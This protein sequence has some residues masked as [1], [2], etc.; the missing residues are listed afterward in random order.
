MRRWLALA[1]LLAPGV[2]LADP[3]TIV[4]TLAPYI[5]GT[6]AAAVA[7]VATFAATYGG[8]IYA[9]YSVY[10]GIQA[11]RD[12]KRAAA[13]A[14]REYNDSLQDRLVTALRADPPWRI[15]YGRAIVGGDIVAVLTSNK[16][17]L[18]NDG[19]TY[20]KPDGLKHLVIVLAAHQVQAIHEVLID[21]IA[22]GTLDGDGWATTG[23]FGGTSRQVYQERVVPAGGS[24]TFPGAPTVLAAG[25]NT[26]GDGGWTDSTYTV[27]GNTV[28]NTA[29]VQAT[30]SVR[31]T[32]QQGTVR[33]EKFLGTADQAASAYLQS[34]CPAEWTANDRLRGLAGVIITLD[35]E[36]PRFQAGPPPLT[37]DVSGRL[38]YDPRT[39]STAY[40]ENPALV[41]RDWLTAPWGFNV[42]PQDIDDAT[43]IAAANA[44]DESISLT[45]GESTTTGARYTCNGATTSDAAPEA[46]L[47]DLARCMAGTATHTGGLWVV[48][49]GVYTPPVLAL[50]EDLKA[51][52]IEVVQAGTGYE[53][54][55]NGVRGSMIERGR[56]VQSDIDPYSNAAYVAADGQELWADRAFRWTDNRARAR[57]LAR[58]WTEQNRESL[59]IQY[60]AKMHAWPLVVG[61]RV[62]VTDAEY[63]WAAKTFR[64][65]DWQWSLESA[66]L[67]TLQEDAASIYDLADAATADSVP[68][69]GL[70]D[71]FATPPA[72]TGLAAASGS[73]HAV[74]Q[75]DGTILDRVRVSWAAIASPY[76]TQ[77]GRVELRWRRLE[78]DTPNAWR[79]LQAPGDATQEYL[80]GARGGDLIVIGATPV[81]SLGARGPEALATHLVVG[82]T[83]PPGNVQNFSVAELPGGLLFDWSRPPDTDYAATVLQ[84]HV[85]GSESTLWDD[86]MP[87]WFEGDATQRLMPWPA[88]GTYAVLARHKDHSGNLSELAALLLVSI[89]DQRLVGITRIWVQTGGEPGQWLASVFDEENG[90]IIGTQPAYW[91][92]TGGNLLIDTPQLEEGAATTVLELEKVYA[93]TVYGYGL[94]VVMGAVVGST[95]ASMVVVTA[96]F[97]ASGVTGFELE[98]WAALFSTPLSAVTFVGTEPDCSD[99]GISAAPPTQWGQA[100]R[101]GAQR[102]KTSITW[103]FDLPAG[104]SWLVGLA[105]QNALFATAGLTFY[106]KPLLQLQ[107]IKA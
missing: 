103:T 71:P 44:C 61:D 53:D 37:F 56:G 25:Y 92:G 30:I 20:T 84:L 91:V 10:G 104:E 89:E 58:I 59:V 80:I 9:A 12:A 98:R 70:P 45:V 32:V 78:A 66:V 79:T 68:N 38:V 24:V 102:T 76:V 75:A 100:A 107:L 62:T 48:S 27:S 29:T 64:V 47:D 97:D 5:G 19:S 94:M 14:R 74:Q 40:S 60:P 11:R 43:V 42:A 87:P 34:V 88:D 105:T 31:Y 49:A 54:L 6:A 16:T 13:R 73:E 57:N 106:G 18:R 28:T 46:V 7:T 86:D 63:G 95:R 26:T 3:I 83:I 33:V 15:V 55:F 17:G 22:V 77:G 41:I 50:T 21:G 2:A 4:A 52:S 101:V 93:D 65:T 90:E 1:L 35:L 81:S 39:A 82:D 23:E 36:E 85:G 99:W 8:Y 96:N 67:L 69:T 72:I 51:G